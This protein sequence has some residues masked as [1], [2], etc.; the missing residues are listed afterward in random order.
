MK[1]RRTRIVQ[2]FFQLFSHIWIKTFRLHYGWMKKV[3]NLSIIYNFYRRSYIYMRARIT[4]ARSHDFCIDAG[5]WNLSFFLSFIL[6]RSTNKQTAVRWMIP[7]TLHKTIKLVVSFFLLLFIVGLFIR[8]SHRLFSSYKFLFPHIHEKK[9][10]IH[11]NH[12]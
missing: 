4:H 6:S 1:I 11:T 7:F 12:N 9:K 3:E 10:N 5:A 8:I 2:V